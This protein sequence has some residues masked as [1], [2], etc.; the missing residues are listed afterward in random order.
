MLVTLLIHTAV[1][2][3]K[4]LFNAHILDCLVHTAVYRTFRASNVDIIIFSF[5]TTG[6]IV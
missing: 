3:A 1:F 2:I 4:K 5:P 6:E